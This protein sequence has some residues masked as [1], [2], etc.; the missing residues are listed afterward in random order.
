MWYHQV[1]HVAL[2][3]VHYL[4]NVSQKLVEKQHYV[5][6]DLDLVMLMLNW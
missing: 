5:V 1:I 6:E 3:I 4:L 2:N